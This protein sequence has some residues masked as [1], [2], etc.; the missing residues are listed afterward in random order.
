MKKLK[1]LLLP[2]YIILNM[3]YVLIGSYLV[4]NKTINIKKI[5][6]RR[7]NSFNIKYISINNF[8][9]NKKN[10]EKTKI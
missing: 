5:L 10:K 1:E 4:I 9:Y 7:N 6:K 3:L 2:I 8:I